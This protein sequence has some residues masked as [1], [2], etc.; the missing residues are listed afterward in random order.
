MKRL[1]DLEEEILGII[2]PLEVDF[3]IALKLIETEDEW[4][5]NG[6]RLF[7]LASVYKVPILVRA[8]QLVDQGILHLSDRVP[9]DTRFKTCPSGILIFPGGRPS[10]DDSRSSCPY[11]H[12]VGQHGHGHGAR[13]GGRD[14]CGMRDAE[15]SRIHG[16]RL[17]SDAVDA[18]DVLRSVRRPAD[19]QDGAGAHRTSQSGSPEPRKRC[20][21]RPPSRECRNTGGDE[22][23]VRT[24]PSGRGGESLILQEGIGHPPAANAR[25]HDAQPAS[26]ID[27]NG[28][29][30]RR[31]A[32]SAQ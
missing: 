3:G 27:P 26:T 4:F 18:R 25:Q 8:L 16:A 31:L 32:W 1:Q 7:Q 19:S 24:H 20:L 6:N 28:T 2:E 10:T 29:Q 21:F 5:L 30:D 12:C 23:I 9:V 22:P 14:R 13:S 15:R 17:P 11:D